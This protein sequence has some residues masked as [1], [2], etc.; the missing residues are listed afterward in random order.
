[1]LQVTSQVLG[2]SPQ[3]IG[4]FEF[5]QMSAAVLCRPNHKKLLG[6][7]VPAPSRSGPHC[8]TPALLISRGWNPSSESAGDEGRSAQLSSCGETKSGSMS[9]SEPRSKPRCC[10]DSKVQVHGTELPSIV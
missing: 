4:Y 2:G 1:V 8:R 9:T 3:S 5:G 7:A 6:S 10:H